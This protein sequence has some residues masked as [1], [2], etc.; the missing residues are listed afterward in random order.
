MIVWQRV[1]GEK[2]KYI[3]Y[4][5]APRKGKNPM[6]S[7]EEIESPQLSRSSRT[8]FSNVAGVIGLLRKVSPS[9][10]I[11]FCWTMSAV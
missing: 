7:I 9:V 6:L 4:L 3:P 10:I 1:S 8:F 11:P 2:W 5:R